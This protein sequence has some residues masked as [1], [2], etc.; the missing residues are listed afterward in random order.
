MSTQIIWVVSGENIESYEVTYELSHDIHDNL[1]ALHREILFS[2]GKRPLDVSLGSGNAMGSKL[3]TDHQTLDD[4]T[5][6]DVCSELMK[7]KKDDGSAE[8]ATTKAMIFDW[9]YL[10]AVNQHLYEEIDLA[11]FSAFTDIRSRFGSACSAARAIAEYKVLQTAGQLEEMLQ[12]FEAFSVWWVNH[13]I[14]GCEMPIR[15]GDFIII[16]KAADH[17]SILS[18]LA[19]C[20]LGVVADEMC[21]KLWDSDGEYIIYSGAFN[22][23]WLQDFTLAI[24]DA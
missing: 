20:A 8:Y 11:G 10:Q 6:M 22:K 19:K 12:N 4:R 15:E 2:L 5:V 16:T 18:R 1:S 14:T 24:S 21:M 7:N 23:E 13:L 17:I 3:A 9:V